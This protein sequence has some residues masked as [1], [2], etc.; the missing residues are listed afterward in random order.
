MPVYTY[1]VRSDAVGCDQC[2]AEFE[3]RQSMS[4]DALAACPSCGAPVQR[5]ITSVGY[6][7]GANY[8]DGLTRERLKAGGLRKLV[9][10]D[11]GRYVDDTPK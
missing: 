7:R 3:L 10:G 5:I 2:S 1:R 4:D 9:K 6:V 8:G 11:D